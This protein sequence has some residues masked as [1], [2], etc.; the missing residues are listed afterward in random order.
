M[1]IS[2]AAG[3]IPVRAVMLTWWV[4][5]IRF[6]VMGRSPT[7]CRTRVV[8]AASRRRSWKS[9][10]GPPGLDR[11]KRQAGGLQAATPPSREHLRNGHP[12]LPL[13]QGAGLLPACGGQVALRPARVEMEPRGVA[14]PWLRRGMAMTTTCPHAASNAQSASWSMAMAGVASRSMAHAPPVTAR[15]L[16][17]LLAPIPFLLAAWRSRCFTCMNRR[18]VEKISGGLVNA[19]VSLPWVKPFDNLAHALPSTS[20]PSAPHHPMA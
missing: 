12:C 16:W 11:A 8:C 3:A 18:G 6:P 5:R 20:G 10:E 13:P 7:R 19:G 15:S 14:H 17:T 1:T 4:T 2:P 9:V